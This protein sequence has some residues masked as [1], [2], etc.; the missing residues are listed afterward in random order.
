MCRHW[1]YAIACALVLCGSAAAQRVELVERDDRD[2]PC[3]RFKMRV[4]VPAGQTDYKLL[5]KKPQ[6]GVDPG[7]VRNPC[8]RVEPQVASSP[9][10]ANDGGAVY[11]AP[12]PFDARPSRGAVGQGD[13]SELL[14]PRMPPAFEMMRPRR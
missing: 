3:R 9:P 12:R 7:M 6:E 4:L 13:P 14:R 2:D 5:V 1:L 11:F 10:S 8:P